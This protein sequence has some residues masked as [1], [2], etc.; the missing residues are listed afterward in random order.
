M[1]T[2][3]PCASKPTKRPSSAVRSNHGPGAVNCTSAVIRGTSAGVITRKRSGARCS[4]ITAPTICSRPLRSTT[5]NAGPGSKSRGSKSA[6]ISPASMSDASAARPASSSAGMPA[7]RA[8]SG[9]KRRASAPP[10]DHSCCRVVRAVHMTLSSGWSVGF[11]PVSLPR[12]ADR[13]LSARRRPG[14]PPPPCRCAPPATSR[15]PARSPGRSPGP[16]P[17]RRRAERHRARS[18]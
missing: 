14:T 3:S 4:P 15:A 16:D 9:L 8:K 5:S 12:R 7:K 10:R 13:F 6:T 2:S 11:M 18:A 1:A 17:R